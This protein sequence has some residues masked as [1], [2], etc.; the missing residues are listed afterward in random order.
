MHFSKF[1]HGSIAI[2]IQRK[3]QSTIPVSEEPVIPILSHT[4]RQYPPHFRTDHKKFS[5]FRSTVK[6]WDDLTEDA[7]THP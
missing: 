4:R 3:D 1:H 2:D 6:D 5:F 7:C